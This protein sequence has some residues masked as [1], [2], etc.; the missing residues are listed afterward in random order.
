MTALPPKVYRYAKLVI[1]KR[2][3]IDQVPEHLREAVIRRVAELV[4]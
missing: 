3:A 2:K 1:A 4:G